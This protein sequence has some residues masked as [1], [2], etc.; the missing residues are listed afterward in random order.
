MLIEPLDPDPEIALRDAEEME[1]IVLAAGITLPQVHHGYD[2]SC[3][4]V[5]RRALTRG[6]GL[7][8]V[9]ILPGGTAAETNLQL[10]EAA[11]ALIAEVT[12]ALTGAALALPLQPLGVCLAF[13]PVG[14]MP[15]YPFRMRWQLVDSR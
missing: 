2:G 12:G 5:N 4:A 8:N 1:A 3:W 11:R 9:A 13:V 14:L 6:H 10:V 7:E 15:C